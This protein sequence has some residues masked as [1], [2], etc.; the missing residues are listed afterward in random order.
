MTHK[1]V[2]TFFATHQT[3][4]QALVMA[5]SIRKFGTSLAAP[6]WIMAP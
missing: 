4:I 1:L 3:Q 6:I 5:R 2:I